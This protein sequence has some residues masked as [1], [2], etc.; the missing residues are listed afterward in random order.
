[1]RKIIASASLAALGTVSMQAAYAPGLSP[2]EQSKPWSVGLAVRGFY[3]DNYTTSPRGS[4]DDSFGISVS[5]SVGLHK[6]FDQ[7]LIA[8]N[9]TYELRWFEARTRNEADHI[10]IVNLRLDHKF[11]ENYRLQVTDRFYHGQEGVVQ[12][13]P[14]VDP[15]RTNADYWRNTA[16]GQFEADFTDHFGMMV[17]YQN[18]IWDYDQRGDQTRS[19]LLDRMEHLGT[20]EGLYHFRPAT[21]G[22]LGYQFEQVDFRGKGNI[23][24]DPDG[25]VLRSNFRDNRSHRVYVGVQHKPT[26]NLDLGLRVGGQYTDYHRA[27]DDAWTPFVDARG[28]YTYNPG[29]FLQ[30]GVVHTLNAT[31]VLAMS[32]E[33]TS[34]WGMVNHRITPRL[35][36]SVLG[37]FQYSSFED[38]RLTVDASRDLLY[39]VGVNLHYRFNPY[40]GAE[41][42][43]NWDK[44][45]SDLPNRSYSRNRV[46]VGVR[47]NY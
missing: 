22:L 26:A 1:M 24:V 18:Q 23:G 36:G 14:Q 41:A 12:L 21:S 47:A 11:S 15:I 16:R 39:L 8:L 19:A 25:N 6:A 27:S 20:I 30:V 2:L 29:S 42:G 4:R 46:Y 43:Y 7:T 44:L 5:P 10:Q 13:G 34:I 3:D 17:A 9:Y 32:Q 35:T 28:T 40:L 31:D 45:D 37:Q 38:G 33:S